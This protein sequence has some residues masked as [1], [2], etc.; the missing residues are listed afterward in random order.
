MTLIV[1]TGSRTG[2]LT[3]LPILSGTARYLTRL[4]RIE[5]RTT[6]DEYKQSV[7][8]LPVIPQSF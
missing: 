7:W 6:F 3:L 1:R 4:N 8:A 5:N 2:F